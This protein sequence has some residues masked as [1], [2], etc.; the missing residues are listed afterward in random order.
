MGSDL[1]ADV[2]FGNVLTLAFLWGCVQFHRHDYNAPWLAYAAFLMPIALFLMSLI[3]T[4]SLP[5]HLDA[6][7][8]Q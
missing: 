5:P 3:A 1:W 4:G 2:F 8:S 6:L 7:A